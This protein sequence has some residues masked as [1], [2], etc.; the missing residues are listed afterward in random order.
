MSFGDQNLKKGREG[1]MY[2]KKEE[3]EKKNEERGKK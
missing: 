1:G 3:R 2:E